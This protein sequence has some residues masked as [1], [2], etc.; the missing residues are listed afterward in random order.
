MPRRAAAFYEDLRRRRTMQ[1]FSD[2]RVPRHI[3]ERCI[4]TAGSASS[5]AHMQP[6][7]FVCR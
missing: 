7:H 4:L 6:W 5:G 1:D 3:I 2:S